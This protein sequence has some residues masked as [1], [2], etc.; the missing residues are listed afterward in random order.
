MMKPLKYLRSLI[1]VLLAPALPLLADTSAAHAALQ[2][3]RVDEAEKTLRAT[4]A[5]NP[6]PPDAPYVVRLRAPRIAVVRR[7]KVVSRAAPSRCELSLPGRPA[8]VDFR[9]TP[10]A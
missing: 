8:S 3:G 5:A 2:H 4:L 7:G 9:F 1:V 6:A 10:P